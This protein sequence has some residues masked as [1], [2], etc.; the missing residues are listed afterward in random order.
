MEESLNKFSTTY[1]H[2]GEIVAIKILAIPAD[3]A[4]VRFL[5]DFNMPLQVGIMLRDETTPVQRH[6]HL[7]RT[8]NIEVTS[9]FIYV[10]EGKCNVSIECT[11]HS[12]IKTRFTLSKNEAAL[13]LGNGIHQIQFLEPTKLLEIKQGPYDEKND[14]RLEN[15]DSS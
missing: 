8:R 15:H 12:E 2:C 9:E 1:S 3:H 10:Q 7:K 5:T 13:F 6:T 14:K 11:N 4:G